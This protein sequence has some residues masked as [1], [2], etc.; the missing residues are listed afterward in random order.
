MLGAALVQPGEKTVFPVA[1]GP[2]VR[3]NGRQKNDCEL[4]ATKRLVSQIRQVIPL[5]KLLITL[6]AL[7]ANAP[8]LRL[9]KERSTI[10]DM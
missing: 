8:L 9:L 2:I 10:T 7:D 1:V 5:D 6:D 4:N 3:Q